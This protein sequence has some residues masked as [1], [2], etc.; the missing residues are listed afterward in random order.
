[1][2]TTRRGFGL[3]DHFPC[4]K[5]EKNTEFTARNLPKMEVTGVESK[6]V[7]NSKARYKYMTLFLQS[8]NNVLQNEVCLDQYSLIELI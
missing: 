7:R 6:Y 3:P 5:F 2:K 4:R 1:M 8:C